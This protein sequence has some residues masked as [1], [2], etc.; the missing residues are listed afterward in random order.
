M[1]RICF[2]DN[3]R[4][5]TSAQ[6]DLTDKR[7]LLCVR[8]VCRTF[9]KKANNCARNLPQLDFTKQPCQQNAHYSKFCLVRLRIRIA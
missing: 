4:D 1:I 3:N 5:K 7:T 8:Y 2:I 9:R 6:P